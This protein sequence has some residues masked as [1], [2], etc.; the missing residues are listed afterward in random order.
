MEFL[1]GNYYVDDFISSSVKNVIYIKNESEVEILQL[2]NGIPHLLYKSPY[3]MEYFK[4]RRKAEQINEATTKQV[5][6]FKELRLQ[7][8]IE[9]KTYGEEMLEEI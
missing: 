5:N 8:G 1:I 7:F 6:M 9:L 3:R 2:L 4:I